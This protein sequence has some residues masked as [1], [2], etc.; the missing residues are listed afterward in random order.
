MKKKQDK[1]VYDRIAVGERLR[2]RRETLGWSR[3]KVAEQIG[4]VDKYYADIER[5]TCGMSIE[6]LIGLSKL[7]GMNMDDLIYGQTECS[8]VLRE[9]TFR[10]GMEG[11]SEQAQ[12]YC[13]KMLGLFM[14][15]MKAAEKVS[16]TKNET[17]MERAE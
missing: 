6:T 2:T 9:E 1:A 14:E 7:Y 13:L 10:R 15:G 16:G 5:G 8:D 17:G 11:L 12:S 3:A 4:I